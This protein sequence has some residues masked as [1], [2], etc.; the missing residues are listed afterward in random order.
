M[1]LAL[2]SC[3]LTICT[4][5]VFAVDLDKLSA[6][7]KKILTSALEKL[8]KLIA[9]KRADNQAVTLTFNE[10]Y[11]PLSQIQRNILDQIRSLNPKQ[12]DI[13]T[14]KLDC[15]PEPTDLVKI[16]GRK[17]NIAGKPHRLITQYLPKDANDDLTAML[18]SMRNEIGK[19]LY[20]ESGYRAPAYQ[21]YL[22]ASGVKRRG[23]SIRKTASSIALPGYSEH[24]CP[25]TQALDFI[26]ADG[27][28][29]NSSTEKFIALPEYAWLKANAKKFN[30]ELSYPP[31]SNTGITFEPWHW[32]HIR[33]K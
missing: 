5:S 30:F 21:L 31:G 7:D 22:F 32:R 23:F 29:C 18:T 14:P 3:L 6:T 2:I 4:T 9:V 13:N 10:L 20:V 8:D 24:G 26:N 16:P 11:Q 28:N 12:L 17:I 19:T 33:K 27:L 1:R 15:G 25:L